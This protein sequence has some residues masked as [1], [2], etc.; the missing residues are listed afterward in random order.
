MLNKK[1]TNFITNRL[2]NSLIKF[3]IS[4]NA[5][6][7]NNNFLINLENENTESKNIFNKRRIDFTTRN[8]MGLINESKYTLKKSDLIN[9]YLI[10]QF[11]KK[12]CVF[13]REIDKSIIFFDQHAVHE[14]IL[15]EYYQELLL[16]EFFNGFDA[17]NTTKS[18][19]NMNMNR[20]NDIKLNLFID[21]YGKYLLKNNKFSM[22]AS[23]FNINMESF[24]KSVLYNNNCNIQTFLNFTWSY[25]PRND[26]ITFYTVPIIFDKIHKIEVLIDIF[27]NIINNIENYWKWFINKKR[28]I[29]E[30]F[31]SVIKS[32]ACRNA[33]KFNDELENKFMKE[34]IYELS[35]CKNP[36]LCAHGRH[37]YFIKYKKSQ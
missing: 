6:N 20:T 31:D 29:L 2:S 11:D 25:S 30:P 8:A 37:N 7:Y 35:F 9:L 24:R 32:K 21:I 10:G 13:Y 4:K 5:V 27:S 16:N 33:V 14:R 28:N 18:N 34:M 26:M 12:F 23:K 22:K 3:N 36:F 15:Y 1:T 19:L 17:I